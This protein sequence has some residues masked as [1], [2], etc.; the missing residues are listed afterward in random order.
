[1]AKH[2]I[3][4]G[5]G[6]RH[7]VD[8]YI[9]FS[10]FA[11]KDFDMKYVILTLRELHIEKFYLKIMNLI[12]Y[13]FNSDNNAANKE[14]LDLT[15]FI[16]TTGAFGNKKQRY[17]NQILLK[18]QNLI[19]RIFPGVATMKNYYGIDF[20]QNKLLILPYWVKLNSTRLK[21]G[22]KNIEDIHDVMNISNNK[23]NYTKYIF[24]MCGL[25]DSLL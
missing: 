12:S 10:H 5:I 13:W 21:R 3:N 22:K 8:T 1:M 7:I 2:F 4:G 18:K 11:D 17:A 24:N 20:S 15:R 9:I 25:D 16:S 23:I 19:K 14:I 6:L